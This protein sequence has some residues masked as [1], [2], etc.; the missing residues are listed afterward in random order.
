MF[1]KVVLDKLPPYY[2]YNHKIKLEPSTSLSY[3]L[4]YS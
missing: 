1:S 2:S 3:G 4:L